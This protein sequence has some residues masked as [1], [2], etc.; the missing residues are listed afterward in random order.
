MTAGPSGSAGDFTATPLKASSTWSGGSPSGDFTW[1]YPLRVPPLAT[2]PRPDMALKYSSQSVDGQMASS[3]NQPGWIGEGFSYHPGSITRSYKACADDMGGTATNKTKTGDLCFGSWNATLSM[4][5]HSGELIRDDT[6]GHYSLKDDDGSKVERLT[7]ATNGANGGEYWKIT[8]SDGTQY[9]FGLNRIAGWA[10]GNPTTNSAFTVPVFGNN[11]GEPCYNATFASAACNQ[12]WQWNLDYVVDTHAGTMSLWYT[13]ETGK[14][15][16]NLTSSSIA[17]YTRGGYLTRIDYGTDQ[18]TSGKDSDLSTTKAPYKVDFA[19]A[20]RCVTPGST[21]TSSTPNNW[22][23]VPWDQNCTSTT[24]CTDYSPTFWSQKRLDNVQTS[25]WNASTTAYDAVEKWTLHQT[26]PDPGDTTRA[27]LWLSS[28]SHSGLYGSTVTLPDVKFA[29]IQLQNRVDTAT[30][31]TPKMNWWRISS[32]TT[33]TG[34]L[35]GVSYST[36]DCT[37]GSTPAPDSNK[38]RCYP[39]Y[40]T[41]AGETKPR[42]DW[43]HKYV[44]TAISENDQTG[45]AQRVFTS[46]T[47]GTPA[48]HYDEDNGLVPESRK[49]W[50]DWRGYDWVTTTVGDTG[51]PQTSTKVHYFQGMNGDKTSTGTRSVQVTDSTGTKVDDEDM[52]AGMKRES[53]T[54]NGPGGAE[55]SGVIE[56]PWKSAAIATRTVNGF[57]VSAYRTGTAA[58][59]SRVALDGGRG[60]RRTESVYTFDGY[61]M[62]TQVWNKGDL[63]VT[64][65]DTCEITTYNRNT[66]A[67]ILETVGRIQKY[68]KPCGTN[69]A[70]QDDVISDVENSFDNQ[71]YG[72]APTKGNITK[73]QTA[74]VWTSATN[75]TWLTTSASVYDAL[76]RVTDATDVRGNH[77][78]TAYTPATGGPVTSVKMTQNPLGW[79]TTTELAP[80][81]GLTTGAVD[82]NNKRTDTT[83][84]GLGRQTAVWSPTRAKATQTANS[85]FDYQISQTA[86]SVVTTKVLN[87]VGNYVPTYNFYDGLLRPRQV[88]EIAPGG[89]RT[90]TDT[91]YNSVD[92]T[93]KTS[94]PYYNGAAPGTT[95]FPTPIDQNVPMQTVTAFDGARRE[96]NTSVLSMGITQR[97]TTTVYGG[98]HTDVTPVADVEPASAGTPTST[99]TDALGRT[100]ETRQY[101]G[102]TVSGTQYNSTKYG[103]NQ[104]GE[105]TTVTDSAGNQR[106]YRYDL[107]GRKISS[108]DPDSGTTSATYNDAGDVTSTTDAL[109][110]TLSYDYT[111]PAGYADPRGRKTAL[112]LGA[113]GTG[114]KLATWTYDTLAKG[115]TTSS[116]RW[117]GASEYKTAM[118]GYNHLYQAAGA[119]ITIPAAEGALAGT[120]TFS[121]TYNLDGTVN[122]ESIPATSDLLAETLNYA[123][124][125]TTG[126]AY[127]LKTNYGGVT[128]QIV[129]STQYTSFGEP[130]VTTFADSST[131]P[132][133]Q[134]ALTYDPATRR[135]AGAK[136]LKSTASNIVGD[137]HYTYNA[138][139]DII[140][141]ADTP[142]GGTANTQCYTFDGLHRLTSAWTPNSGE[143]ATTPSVAGLGGAAPYWK[144]WTFDGTGVAGSTGNRLT[145]TTHTAGGDTTVTSAYSQPGHP[146][147]VSATTTTTGGTQTGTASY[148]YD[149]NGNTT[150][151]PGSRGQQALRWDAE[152]HLSS[153]T[154][155]SG[156]HSYVYNADGSRLLARDPSGATLYVGSVQLRLTTST[157]AKTAQRYY[158]FNERAV[159]QRTAAGVQFLTGD[160]HGTSLIAI[161]NTATQAVTKRYQDPYGNSVGT[162]VAWIGTKTFVGGD[163]DPTGLEHMGAREYD[164][165]LGRFISRDPVFD[166]T[167]SQQIN[168]YAYAN[169]NPITKSDPSGLMPI[170]DAYGSTPYIKPATQYEKPKGSV[171]GG[172][173]NY[174]RPKPP[175]IGPVRPAP[176]FRAKPPLPGQLFYSCAT[177][178]WVS[179]GASGVGKVT[180]AMTGL[181]KTRENLEK[182]LKD[183]PTKQQRS[184]ALQGRNWMRDEKGALWTLSKGKWA[185]YGS[186]IGHGAMIIGAVSTYAEEIEE[187]KSQGQAITAGAASGLG[188]WAG[189]EVGAVWG[190]SLGTMVCPG[191]GTVI[192][193]VI[194]G[195][196]G[197]IAGGYFGQ[198]LV[199][200]SW[201]HLF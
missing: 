15:A 14:Y 163:Q 12:A 88:Q 138:A 172:S 127:S 75:I 174:A 41:R 142:S 69:P 13:Q 64:G 140:S 71:A 192:G 136:T 144:A 16:K 193:G 168:G 82:E 42:I 103:F 133:A 68:A 200:L 187:G 21:C 10:T 156:T 125:S 151:R 65:D 199:D 171:S 5:G 128:K 67:N 130:A 182:G 19:V 30:D 84:D 23:D 25:V 176:T 7:G 50:G 198:K 8:T 146:H 105:N 101:P 195:V 48:W 126:R 161:D 106:S 60:A 28:I 114:T 91:F 110:Q 78:L 154:D 43:F 79:T 180:D 44:V 34:D 49:T 160:P 59:R 131:A 181:E 186:N 113:I 137:V 97:H 96:I 107:L 116:S 147:G 33:E 2:G 36:P 159:A 38:S 26:Y 119:T 150:S 170:I 77:T 92:E 152:N 173:S 190:A 93:V 62:P 4:P 9:F 51:D 6:D 86:P 100:V 153:L 11:P 90:V 45:G 58:T 118:L 145:E 120:Y 177:N 124:D 175:F 81:Y 46:Y 201:K 134:Q 1:S 70:S 139:G 188:G 112:W 162:A 165:G 24:S 197:G 135:L 111:L 141:S 57:T 99:I 179:D 191:V 39:G 178:P 122:S 149:A 123:Y 167:D 121:A 85:T 129:L 89:G 164:A 166:A 52:Y 196:A 63:A 18:R 61:G 169:N 31:N 98:D 117:A 55:V 155:S 94:G 20:D 185:K 72:T 66:T 83:F 102:T 104:K 22:P 53:F 108:A 47:Y 40:W 132:W 109:N 74:K 157:A 115:R 27:G 35:I 87:A 73:V 189:A 148:V 158:T 183:L 17:S 3:N 56:D 80:G 95:L 184:A 143:C 54:Y 32:I 194:G 29:G 37:A 76:G